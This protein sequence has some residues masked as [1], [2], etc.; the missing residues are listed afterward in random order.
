MNNT[1][2]IVIQ[3]GGR[4]VSKEQFEAMNLTDLFGVDAVAFNWSDGNVPT[5]WVLESVQDF[6][7]EGVDE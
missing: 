2:L 5:E 1:K 3:V 4:P 7:E 6:L